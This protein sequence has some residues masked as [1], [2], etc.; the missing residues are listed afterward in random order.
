MTMTHNIL[1]GSLYRVNFEQYYER[2][3]LKLEKIP[4][5]TTASNMDSV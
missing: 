4:L 3:I 2:K 1:M 5:L